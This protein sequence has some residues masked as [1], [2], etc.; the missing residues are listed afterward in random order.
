MLP[1]VDARLERMRCFAL[2][3]ALFAAA[4]EPALLYVYS[5][6]APGPEWGEL[7]KQCA[8]LPKENE[9]DRIPELVISPKV[10]FSMFLLW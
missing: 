4:F 2:W 10:V 8:Y 3:G 5:A 6:G 9:F 1:F 7:E